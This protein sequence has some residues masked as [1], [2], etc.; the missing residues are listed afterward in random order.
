MQEKLAKDVKKNPKAFYSYL[1]SRTSNKVTVGPLKE[2]EEI[3]TD[4]NKIADML[5]VFFS[6]VFTQ[7]V[8]YTLVLI[9]FDL[10]LFS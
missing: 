10:S 6:S 1:K 8:L 3:V 2:G 7:K 5:N 9:L 4:D